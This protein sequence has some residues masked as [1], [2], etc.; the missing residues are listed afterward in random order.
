M[1]PQTFKTFT[2]QVRANM[3][4]VADLNG[5]GI[6]ALGETLTV[7]MSS[8]ETTDYDSAVSESRQPSIE[9]N[10]MRRSIQELP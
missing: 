9:P 1:P 6:M 2:R 10:V 8:Q 5:Q 3:D 4:Q 7:L